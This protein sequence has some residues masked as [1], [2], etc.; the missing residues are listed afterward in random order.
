MPCAPGHAQEPAP[1]LVDIEAGRRRVSPGRPP[2]NRDDQTPSAVA[3]LHRSPSSW[4]LHLS[5]RRETNG[6]S[7]AAAR[8]SRSRPDVADQERGATD[9]PSDA[10]D[11]G[12][13]PRPEHRR[14]IATPPDAAPCTPR[15]DVPTPGGHR[16]DRGQRVPRAADVATHLSATR[17]RLGL[18]N[19]RHRR[20]REQQR[21]DQT[22]RLTR[23]TGRP[24]PPAAGL[25]RDPPTAE[26]VAAA[27]AVTPV[28]RRSHHAPTARRSVASTAPRPPA[29]SSTAGVH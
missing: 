21:P 23:H 10:D 6:R 20:R 25:H 8:G 12:P 18:H 3:S 17:R 16:H 15:G 5:P 19:L 29:P 14:H 11:V 4:P 27:S 9:S 24:L 1:R 22:H 2:G 13:A 7:G 26:T 28:A